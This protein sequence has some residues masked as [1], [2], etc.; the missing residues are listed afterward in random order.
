MLRDPLDIF[1]RSGYSLLLGALGAATLA[2]DRQSAQEGLAIYR[3]AASPQYFRD[4]RKA[5]GQRAE[6]GV[7][8]TELTIWLMMWQRLDEKG[9]LSTAVQQVIEGRPRALL[10]RHKR[11]VEKTVSSNTGGYSQARGRLDQKVAKEV[12]GRIFDYLMADAREA[13][14]GLGRQA[15]LLDGSSLDLPATAELLKAYPP[16]QNQYGTT[17]WPVVRIVVAHDLVS[18]IAMPP[19][20][21]P[22]YGDQAVSEQEL[23]AQGIGQLPPGSVVV[24]DRNFGVFSTV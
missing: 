17:H 8:T 4:L 16:A 19:V 10:P 13:L 2:V 6:G 21:G 11:L 12:A 20:W 18:G 24:A 14:P 1:V 5:S 23:A 7:Y 15:F 9:T 22:M 3:A